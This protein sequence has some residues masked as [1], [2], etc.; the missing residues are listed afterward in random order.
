M[1]VLQKA[2]VSAIESD[3]TLSSLLQLGQ[4]QPEP[5]RQREVEGHSRRVMPSRGLLCR[6]VL[7]CPLQFVVAPQL[8]P[9]HQQ[10]C[11]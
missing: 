1:V 6:L 7:A 4:P 10:A 3:R 2:G 11:L 8:W 5:D 9:W